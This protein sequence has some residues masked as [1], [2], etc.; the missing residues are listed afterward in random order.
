MCVC[1][2]VVYLI[3]ICELKIDGLFILFI[4]EK[5]ILVVGVIC[6]DGF[7]G[8]NIMENFKCVKDI[9]LILLEELDI[10]VCGECY[11]LCVFFD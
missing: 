3:Y 10:I 9:F 11:M 6:G 2:E 8:E 5:G 4:Y 1:K 7:V